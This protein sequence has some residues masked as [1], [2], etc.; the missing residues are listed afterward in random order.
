MHRASHAGKRCRR[1][2]NAPATPPAPLLSRPG[3]DPARRR[4]R[5]LVAAIAIFFRLPDETICV[6]L[7]GGLVAVLKA[8]TTADLAQWSEASPGDGSAS[9]ANLDA[10]KRAASD[11]RRFLEERFQVRIDVAVGRY[12][13]RLQGLHTSYEDCRLALRL[14]R[15]T[16]PG[17][18]HSL[19]E[20]GLPALLAVA[21]DGTK[22]SLAA[23]LIGP[24]MP[25]P[26]ILPTL[27]AFFAENCSSN[28]TARK[29]AI[30]RNT[31]SY[32]LD[33]VAV[34]TGLDPR[35]FND[36]IQLRISLELA[37]TPATPSHD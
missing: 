37:D 34:L 4:I 18:M 9:W 27:H 11:L 3:G 28:V 13:P 25:E 22:R 15:V 6:H 8:C 16:R 12:H 33:K 14:G 17:S 29:L 20:L 31:L 7:Q 35:R 21:D 30:H 10:L 36:A 32:R 26:D 23:R 5:S 2:C 24:L 19:D 1:P